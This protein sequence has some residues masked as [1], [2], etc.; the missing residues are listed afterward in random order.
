MKTTAKGK[1]IVL[2]MVLMMLA[3]CMVACGKQEPV[4]TEPP[5]IYDDTPQTEPEPLPPV[6]IAMPHFE[7]EYAGELNDVIVVKERDGQNVLDFFVKLSNTEEKIYTMN[8]DSEEGDL[9]E[10]IKDKS[11][12]PVNIAFQMAPIPEGL[13]DADHLT[14]CVAQESVNDIVASLV[15]K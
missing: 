4:Q 15:I 10:V 3:V 1:I 11:G 7:L 13:S 5:R 6:H 2:L 12:N 14:F 9:V 8:Y